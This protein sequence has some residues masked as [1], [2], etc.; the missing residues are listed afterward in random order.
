VQLVSCQQLPPPFQSPETPSKVMA[1]GL[2]CLD[3]SPNINTAIF[4]VVLAAS[5]SGLANPAKSKKSF[6]VFFSRHL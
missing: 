5:A 3:A 1:L 2:R 4:F 6:E